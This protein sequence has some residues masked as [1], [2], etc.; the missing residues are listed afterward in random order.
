MEESW[1]VRLQTGRFEGEPHE[2]LLYYSSSF[3]P[4]PIAH[5]V[6]QNL[7][8]PSTEST[9]VV[10]LDV[11]V[12]NLRNP[13]A[14]HLDL[15][16]GQAEIYRNRKWAAVTPRWR[17]NNWAPRTVDSHPPQTPN[18]EQPIKHDSVRCGNSAIGHRYPRWD[19]RN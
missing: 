11:R 8:P 2:V 13:T 6:N 19:V 9:G 3:L 17:R 7:S 10:F 5:V 12:V 18:K 14:Q 15:S 4:K 16:V 1:K